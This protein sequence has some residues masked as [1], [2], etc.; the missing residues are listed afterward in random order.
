V[1][2]NG[3]LGLNDPIGFFICLTGFSLQVWIARK[4]RTTLLVSLIVAIAGFFTFLT[5]QEN[6]APPYRRTYPTTVRIW[7]PGL[8][9][10]WCVCITAIWAALTVR[11][12]IPPFNPNR[13]ALFRSTTAVI[14]AAP[15]AV[16]AF[17]IL[18]RKDFIVNEIDLKFP[19]LPRDLQNLRLLQLSDIHLSPFYQ[20][21]DLVQIVDAANELRPD[22]AIV[23]GDLITS[24]NDPLDACLRQLSRLK[25][26]SGIWGCMGNHER[27]AHVQDY[28]AAR[29]AS[30]G[31]KFLRFEAARLKFGSAWLNL[32]GVDY[33][34]LHSDYLAGTEELVNVGDFNLLLSH[35]PDVFPVAASKGFDLVMAGHTHGGQINVEILDYNLNIADFLSPYTKGLYTKTASSIYVN[36]GIGT[37][38]IP[39]RVGSPPEITLLRLCAS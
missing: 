32:A 35:N 15:V 34:P 21:K 18:T 22:L 24:A 26:V 30:L 6:A 2:L 11:N 8:T 10:A 23:T 7:L 5:M 39:I 13:R 19:S 25:N 38:G 17:G 33:Q 27:Y 4:N 16:T 28:A 36:S 29:G 14:C 12:R 1:D 9:M 3:L 37:I 20:E 31:I